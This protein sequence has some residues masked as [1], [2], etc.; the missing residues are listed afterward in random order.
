MSLDRHDQFIHIY[1]NGKRSQQMQVFT[2]HV[3]S[4]ITFNIFSNELQRACMIKSTVGS[5]TQ[6]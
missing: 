1:L 6:N 2:F 5:R 4:L 3:Q